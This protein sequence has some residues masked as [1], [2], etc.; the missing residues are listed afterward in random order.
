MVR[1]KQRLEIAQKRS[2]SA[3]CLFTTETNA[4]FDGLNAMHTDTKTRSHITVA[5]TTDHQQA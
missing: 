4:R 1:M 2:V 3:G 5:R